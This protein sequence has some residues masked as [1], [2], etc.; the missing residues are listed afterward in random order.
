MFG[1]IFCHLTYQGLYLG[2][3]CVPW[4]AWVLCTVYHWCSLTPKWRPWQKSAAEG[5]GVVFHSDISAPHCGASAAEFRR[6]C[7]HSILHLVWGVSLCPFCG[8]WCPF[9]SGAEGFECLLKG[10]RQW[11]ST[12]LMP[13][14]FN[15]APRV[16]VIAAIK[17]FCCYFSNFVMNYNANMCIF[18]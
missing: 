5:D 16:V 2:R 18:P 15:V 10:L 8:W 7:G 6:L 12:F 3:L 17:L 13:R 11:F 14:P 1:A 4:E 9:V